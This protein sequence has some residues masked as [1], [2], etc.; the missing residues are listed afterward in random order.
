MSFLALIALCVVFDTG[1]SPRLA[2]I[3]EAP[4]FQL[5][6]Q[7]HKSVRLKDSNGH[8]RLVSFIF[9]TCSGSCPETTNRLARAQQ[10]LEERKP[11]KWENVQFL[12]ISLDPRRDTPD[13]LR[14]YMKLYN[15]RPEHWSCLTGTEEVIAKTLHE[16]DMWAKPAA[17]GQ[18]D[19]PSRV[20]LLDR[21]GRIR[22]IYNLSFLKPKWVLEDLESLLKEKP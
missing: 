1:K 12:S 10:A 9:T 14:S 19:H 2:V 3:R 8:V 16:W 17:N 4:D 21:Q 13:V 6:S 7:D 15:L 5:I 11:D 22:E 18:L 20:F